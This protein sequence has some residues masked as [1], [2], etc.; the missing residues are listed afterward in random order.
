MKIVSTLKIFRINAGDLSLRV[1]HY[2]DT[3][4]FQVKL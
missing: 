4:F 1:V 2:N 3:V